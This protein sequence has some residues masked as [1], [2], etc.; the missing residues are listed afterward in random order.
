MFPNIRHVLMGIDSAGLTII[1]AYSNEEELNQV[2]FD[3]EKKYETLYTINV[4]GEKIFTIDKVHIVTDTT[5]E[6]IFTCQ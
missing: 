3:V 4:P 2:I 5:R 6:R 1:G